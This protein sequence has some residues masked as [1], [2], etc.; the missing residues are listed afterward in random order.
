MPT[1]ESFLMGNPPPIVESSQ[2]L[3]PTPFQIGVPSFIL[4]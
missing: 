1:P 2:E 3:P 4:P